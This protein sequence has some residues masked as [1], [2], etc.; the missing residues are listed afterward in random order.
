V[1]IV[2]TT[3]PIVVTQN[4]SVELDEFGN[5]S[6]SADDIDDDS[7]DACGIA[8]M[9]L[10]QTS[11]TCP[12]LGDHTVTLTVVDVNGNSASEMAIVTFTSDDLDND[13]IADVCDDDMDGDGVNNDIDN[14]P[15]TANPD[16]RDLDRNGI[17]DICDEGDLEIPKGFSPNGDGVNDEFIIS[18]LHNYP[19]NSIQI[20]NRYGNIVFESKAYQN[21]WDGTGNKKERKLPVAPYFYALSID[22]GMRIVKGWVYINY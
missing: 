16:Q 17:G 15:T 20:Y 9:S 21:F 12:T 3:A 8:S 19:N 6:I 2:D 4:I 7:F 10:D 1:T 13:N 5:A 22:G 18:G 11:F 14:C